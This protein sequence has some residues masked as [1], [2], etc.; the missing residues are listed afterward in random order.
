MLN[1]TDSTAAVMTLP[2]FQEDIKSIKTLAE[3]QTEDSLAA[4]KAKAPAS[5]IP[6]GN[7][8]VVYGGI[9]AGILILIVAIVAIIRKKKTT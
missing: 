4:V 8:S 7:S 5:I 6:S 2:Q 3:L 1:V 9:A